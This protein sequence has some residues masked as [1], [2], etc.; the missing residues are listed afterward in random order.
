M[1]MPTFAGFD[2]SEAYQGEFEDQEFL[3]ILLSEQ[4]CPSL[5]QELFGQ[6]TGEP[7][8]PTQNDT[9]AAGDSAENIVTAPITSEIYAEIT[10][11]ESTLPNIIAPEED[12]STELHAVNFHAIRGSDREETIVMVPM[13]MI[14]VD[15]DQENEGNA[16]DLDSYLRTEKW[17]RALR[18]LDHMVAN[19]EADNGA[20]EAGAP[21]RNI[22]KAH[23]ELVLWLRGQILLE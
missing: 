14:V 16:S 21:E 17:E 3:S 10:E 4:E 7:A 6:V 9:A 18:L 5:M 23:P 8:A 15:Q 2:N 19:G 20:V 12:A 13:N 22:Y 11:N 1:H